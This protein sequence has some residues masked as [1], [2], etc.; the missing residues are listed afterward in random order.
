M[1]LTTVLLLVVVSLVVA[2]TYLPLVEA[3]Y[4][5][6]CVYEEEDAPYLCE[7]TRWVGLEEFDPE[8][9]YGRPT[10]DSPTY[11]FSDLSHRIVHLYLRDDGDTLRFVEFY[12][13]IGEWG[14][15]PWRIELPIEAGREWNEA[16]YAAIVEEVGS[17]TIPAGEFTDCLRLTYSFIGK[18]EF[19]LG[20]SRWSFILASG[21]GV[22]A[23]EYLDDYGYGWTAELTECIILK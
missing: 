8:D 23:E 4:V 17:Y 15:L 14:E 9:E 22:I 18:P 7:E 2:D 6:S 13:Q 16:G 1:R 21:V 10:W 20:F 3:E 5:F 12:C 19:S 11:E